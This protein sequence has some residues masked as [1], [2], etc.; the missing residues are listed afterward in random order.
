MKSLRIQFID[1]YG[2]AED[3]IDGGGLLKEFMTKVTAEIF[4]LNRAF[5]SETEGKDRY[6]YPSI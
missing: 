2:Q 1:E 5:F 6:L 3:G 4:D